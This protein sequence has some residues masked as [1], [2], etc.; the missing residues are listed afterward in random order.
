MGE[1]VSNRFKLISSQADL[2]VKKL[3]F[4]MHRDRLQA[5]LVMTK[6]KLSGWMS[7]FGHLSDV[8]AKLGDCK[9]QIELRIRSNSNIRIIYLFII[10]L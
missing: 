7:K 10:Y 3:E 4:R 9:V 8:E 2:A 6:E 1:E 5:M